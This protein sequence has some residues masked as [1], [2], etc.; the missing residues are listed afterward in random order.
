MVEGEQPTVRATSR[1]R[2]PRSVRWAR[3]GEIESFSIT[4]TSNETACPAGPGRRK[5]LSL[6]GIVKVD[7]GARTSHKLVGSYLFRGV[8]QQ[9]FSNFFSTRA[10]AAAATRLCTESGTGT[11]QPR[12]EHPPLPSLRTARCL[13]PGRLRRSGPGRRASHS[14]ARGSVRPARTHGDTGPAIGEQV[15]GLTLRA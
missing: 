15:T 11:G 1:R 10:Y 4:C 6:L 8:P 9:D 7:R 14:G 5:P 3:S 12:A 2:S 13:R